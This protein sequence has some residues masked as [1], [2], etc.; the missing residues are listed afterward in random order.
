ML[1]AIRSAGAWIDR[2]EIASQT[3]KRELAPN[4]LRHLN[5][6]EAEGYIQR[7]VVPG[8]GIREKFEYM[9]TDKEGEIDQDTDQD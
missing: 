5:D 6:L 3:G 7:R 4:D 8:S 2:A 9:A 1:R